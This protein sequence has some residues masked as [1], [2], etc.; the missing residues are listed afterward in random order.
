MAFVICLVLFT[1]LIR[2]FISFNPAIYLT[3]PA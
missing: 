1:E 3:F 2:R